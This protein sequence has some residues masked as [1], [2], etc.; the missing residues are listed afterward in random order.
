MKLTFRCY[1]C[2]IFRAITIWTKA[3]YKA[4]YSKVTKKNGC[5]HG[6]LTITTLRTYNITRHNTRYIQRLCKDN[7]RV[8]YTRLKAQ[9]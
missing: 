6:D 7:S 8:N 5:Y 1:A 9:K 3:L 4:K 2:K